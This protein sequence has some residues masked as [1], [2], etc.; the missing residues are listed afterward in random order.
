MSTVMMDFIRELA[1]LL[2]C[3]DELALVA[4]GSLFLA[5]LVVIFLGA[6]SGGKLPFCLCH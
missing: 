3:S 2:G 5:A 1:S 4:I 6:G